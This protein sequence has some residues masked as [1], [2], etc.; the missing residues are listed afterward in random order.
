MQM[1]IGICD[2]NQEDRRKIESIC[3]K[4]LLKLSIPYEILEFENGEKFL[5][6]NDTIDLLIL[7]IEMPRLTGID[8]KEYLQKIDKKTLIIFVTNHDELV[9]SAFGINVY[10]FVMKKT[11]E[12]QLFDMIE[13]AVLV[14]NQYVIIDGIIDSR[15]ICY[16]KS[17]RVYNTL[18]MA[19]GSEKLLRASLKE[20]E[21][22][23][24]G[25]GFIRTHRTYLV[26]AKWIIRIGEKEVFLDK[27]KIPVS[28][29]LRKEVNRKYRDYCEKNARYC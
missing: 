5:E 14:I 15:E 22:Q 19:D 2:D 21:E 1:I 16:I 10:G 17:E 20:L 26:N 11:L 7:D 12:K 24:V 27:K 28:V 3:N 9:L 18:F 23:L 4:T 13:S 25:V 8:V 6:C 29:R